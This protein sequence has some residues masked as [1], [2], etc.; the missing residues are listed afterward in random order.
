MKRRSGRGSAPI[1]VE[2]R[3]VRSELDRDLARVDQL[4]RLLDAQFSIAGV[5]FGWDALIGLVPVAGDI[6]T[7]LLA[8][9]PVYLAGRHGLGG[10]TIARMLG[11]VGLDLLVGAVPVLGDVF[12]VA[13]KA[14][15][16][17]LSLFRKAVERRRR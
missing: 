10:W 9:Y 15:R 3:A 13:F 7:G 12:D 6:T 8:L 2:V 17:N 1:R 5:R 14:N 4:S 11:N 16:R